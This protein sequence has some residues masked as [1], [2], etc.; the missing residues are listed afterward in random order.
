[1]KKF[2]V[3]LCLVLF[4]VGCDNIN[5][6]DETHIDSGI[7]SNQNVTSKKITTSTTTT[8]TTT[9]STTTTTTT[10]TTATTKKITTTRQTTKRTTTRKSETSNLPLKAICNDGTIS[11]QNDA[12]KPDYRGMCSH[13][14]G[15]RTKLGRVK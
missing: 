10:R 14:G 15:I 11:Y 5:L 9:T 13:H 2:I 7:S 6:E 8:K 1:M 3:L 12:S 4:T